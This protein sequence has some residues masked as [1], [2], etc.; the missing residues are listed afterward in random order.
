[1][2]YIKYYKWNKTESNIFLKTC[3][4]YLSMND[5]QIYFPIMSLYFH[6]HNTKNATKFIDIERQFYLK[7]IKESYNIKYNNLNKILKG[8]IYDSYND[9]LIDK[10][11]FCKCIPILDPIHS[12]MKNYSASNKLLPSNYIHNTQSKINNLNNSCYIDVFFSYI[13]SKLTTLNILPSFPI[14]YGLANGISDEF[15]YDISDEYND[16][17]NEKWFHKN[18]GDLFSIDLYVSDTDD[19]T[20]DESLGNNDDIICRLFKFPVQYLFIEKLN[21]TLEDFLEYDINIDTLESCLFQILYALC[22]LQKH[23]NFT[24]NDLHINNVMYAKTDKLYLYYK[25]NNIY[26]KIPTHGYIFKIIDFGRSIFTYKNRVFHNEV[27]SK[28]GEAEG[29][30]DYPIPPVSCYKNNKYKIDINPNNSFDMCRLSMTILEELDNNENF[31]K[32]DNLEL[33]NFLINI[34]IDKNGH[35]IYLER[36][37]SFDL[38]INIA[39]NACNGLPNNLII[40]DIFK[41]YRIKKKMFPNTG[42]RLN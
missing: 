33:Y 7:E 28:Y 6:I 41:K 29:Q 1:M 40:N 35:N 24:H 18:I 30:Y 36:T 11:I 14:F 38:Y 25:Y 23:F 4:K 10:E 39:K 15:L 8:V 9:T 3:K 13:V 42:Y 2:D 16:F 31:N 37:E 26:F 34:V 27:F 22:Y 5:P 19:S 17:I 32:R 21:G 20:D 12:I